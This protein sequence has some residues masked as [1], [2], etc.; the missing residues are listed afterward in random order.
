V[1]GVDADATTADRR[2]RPLEKLD[3]RTTFVERYPLGS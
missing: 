1:P 2:R 3:R